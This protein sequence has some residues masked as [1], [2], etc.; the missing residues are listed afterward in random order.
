MRSCGD[1]GYK[2]KAGAPCGYKIADG[3]ESC[4]HHDPNGSRARSF[5]AK[6]TAAAQLRQLP[7]QLEGMD[8]KTSD[9][10][11]GILAQVIGLA[12]SKAGIDL[13]R[14]DSVTKAVN[15]AT[16]LL[17]LDVLKD[18]SDVMAKADG[19]GGAILILERLRNTGLKPIPPPKRSSDQTGATA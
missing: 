7:S 4:P 11:R 19:H 10:L 18:L 5:Q 13:R 6:G 8:L 16:S 3:A 2:T 14:L 1:R 15:S 9:G 17:Q 12:S